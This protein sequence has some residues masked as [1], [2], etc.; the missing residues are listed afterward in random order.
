MVKISSTVL[1][2][3]IQDLAKTRLAVKIFFIFLVLVAAESSGSAIA[4]IALSASL[5][6]KLFILAGFTVVFGLV[7]LLSGYG[8]SLRWNR[9]RGIFCVSLII[10]A[11]LVTV[12]SLSLEPVRETYFHLWHFAIEIGTAVAYYQY[13]RALFQLLDWGMTVEK[14]YEFAAM[15]VKDAVMELQGQHVPSMQIDEE[16]AIEEEVVKEPPDSRF[17]QF[18]AANKKQ[19][20]RAEI[21]SLETNMRA[22]LDARM[23]ERK[24]RVFTWMW[25]L[26]N[27]T[28]GGKTA[29]TGPSPLAKFEIPPNGAMVTAICRNA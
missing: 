2:E 8:S 3:Q 6:A 7:T 26:E 22:A 15:C 4:L 23:P 16:E 27:A 19:F 10:T 13:T 14:L 5:S 29:R 9:C 17:L 21:P 28:S 1:S 25:G 18:V 24:M 20:K 12:V 11:V